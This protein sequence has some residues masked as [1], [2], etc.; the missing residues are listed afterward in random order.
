MR[1]LARSKSRVLKYSSS[2]RIWNVTAG[3][4]MQS[5]S[6]AR[7]NERCFATAWNTCRRRSAMASVLSSIGPHDSGFAVLLEGASDGRRRQRAHLELH[8]SEVTHDP[9]G[10]RSESGDRAGIGEPRL[11]AAHVPHALHEAL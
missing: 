7:V 6:A 2:W 1:P 4:V 8:R 10:R 9:R 11:G 5:A 3:W